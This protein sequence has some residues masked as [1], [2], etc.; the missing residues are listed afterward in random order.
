MTLI[1]STEVE[2]YQDATFLVYRIFEKNSEHTSRGGGEFFLK[3]RFQ[4]FYH[5]TDPEIDQH[6]H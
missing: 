5:Y 4:G 1:V 3:T 2:E 6:C